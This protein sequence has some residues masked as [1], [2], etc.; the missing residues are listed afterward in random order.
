MEETTKIIQESAT[1]DVTTEKKEKRTTRKT[2]KKPSS[3]KSSVKAKSAVKKSKNIDISA[4]IAANDTIASPVKKKDNNE[5]INANNSSDLFL[6]H[7]GTNCKAYN[8]LGAKPLISGRKTGVIFRVWAP[9]ALSVSVVGDFNEWDRLKNPMKRCGEKGVWQTYISGIK[10]YDIYKYS[11]ET[12]DKKTVLKADPYAYHMETRPDT[13][14]RFYDISGYQWGDEAWFNYKSRHTVSSSPINIYE[15]HAGSWKRYP[16]GNCFE[17]EKLADELITYVKEMGYTHIELMPITE[18]PL[19][20]SWGYQVTGYYAPTSRY[21]SPK[22]FMAFVDKC[23][24]SGVGVIVDWVPAHFPKDA[25][26]LYEFDG[27]CCYEYAD[28]LKREHARVGN[29][30]F[31]LQPQ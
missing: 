10:E 21:G 16:D 15:V 30:H 1:L 22:D 25:H 7:E 4:E 2:A 18:H 26:G 9:A 31:R 6:F 11:I 12:P 17:Y 23:H 8:F 24:R 14:S 19:D 3:E 28:P 29:A 13:A 20:E 27:T 5:L